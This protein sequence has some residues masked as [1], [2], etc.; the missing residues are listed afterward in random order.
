MLSIFLEKSDPPTNIRLVAKPDS[1]TVSWDAPL[2]K[3]NF[4]N[5]E[6][7]VYYSENPIDNNNKG[8][9]LPKTDRL[10]AI[11]RPLPPATNYYIR[12]TAVNDIGESDFSEIK[13]IST[14]EKRKCLFV[15]DI[16][17]I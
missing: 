9:T 5:I 11:I 12:V 13:S 14:K 15:C 10:T 17:C 1:I 2:F 3:G 6:Y 8:K 16:T 4:D 7:K